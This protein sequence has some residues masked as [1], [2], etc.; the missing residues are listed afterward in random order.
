MCVSIAKLCNCRV[1]GVFFRRVLR[2]YPIDDGLAPIDAGVVGIW[3]EFGKQLVF[4]STGV[5][6]IVYQNV[7]L[8]L[9]IQWFTA[10][11]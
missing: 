7:V 9:W 11:I 8:L 2:F 6:K 10:Q 4:I 1:K 5:H 3:V